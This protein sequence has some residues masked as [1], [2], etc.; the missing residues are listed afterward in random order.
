MDIKL[1]KL[2]VW[3]RLLIVCG[4]KICDCNLVILLYGNYSF[5]LI[6]DDF[7]ERIEGRDYMLEVF[8]LFFFVYLLLY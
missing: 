3:V 4:W 2:E 1:D 7:E 6:I 8:I 5:D